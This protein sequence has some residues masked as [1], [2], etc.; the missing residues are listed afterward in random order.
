MVR[1]F[2]IY[3]SYKIYNI[4]CVGEKVLGFMGEWGCGG[5]WL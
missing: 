5:G 4:S 1:E 3:K 2:K